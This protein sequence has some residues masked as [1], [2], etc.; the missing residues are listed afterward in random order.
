MSKHAES[1]AARSN[2]IVPMSDIRPK[3]INAFLGSRPIPDVQR[4]ILQDAPTGVWRTAAN[5]TWGGQS[6]TTGLSPE[7][8]VAHYHLGDAAMFILKHGADKVA[9]MPQKIKDQRSKYK[10]LKYDPLNVFSD[11]RR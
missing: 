9:A 2:H 3:A 7:K 1:A 6:F 4:K 11:R 10:S 5:Q 8:P